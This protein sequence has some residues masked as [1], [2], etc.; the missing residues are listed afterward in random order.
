[1][2]MNVERLGICEETVVHC[3]ES[4]Y[5]PGGPGEN[6]ENNLPWHAAAVGH[7]LNITIEGCLYTNLLDLIIVIVILH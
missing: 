1:M 5:W 7:I 3:L 6:N 4:R 2:N